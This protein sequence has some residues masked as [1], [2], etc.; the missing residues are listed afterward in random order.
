MFAPR[1]KPNFRKKSSAQ[2]TLG[3]NVPS[4]FWCCFT[5]QDDPNEEARRGGRRVRKREGKSGRVDWIGKKK[6][7]IKMLRVKGKD[8][9]TK[10]AT[11]RG[12]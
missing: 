4:L 9:E 10:H 8:R 3:T 2:V 6:K 12:R 7:E 1:V 11:Q 5:K